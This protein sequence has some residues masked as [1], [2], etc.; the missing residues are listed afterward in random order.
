L[1]PPKRRILRSESFEATGLAR[2][3]EKKD[4]AKMEDIDGRETGTVMVRT[5]GAL[6]NAIATLGPVL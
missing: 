5:S 3:K 2:H 4:T 1:R 6:N